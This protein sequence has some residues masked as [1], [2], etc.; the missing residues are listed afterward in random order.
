MNQVQFIRRV[1]KPTVFVLSLL[2]FA[3]LVRAAFSGGL[4]ANPIEEITHTTGT[5]ALTYLMLTLTI[6]PARRLLNLNGLIHLRRMVGLFAFFY[7]SLHFLTYF[8]LD[9]YFDFEAIIEDIAKRPYITIGFVAFSLLVPLAVTSTN[10]MI[11]RLGGK[12]WRRLHRLV[13]V[14]AAGGVLHYLWQVKVEERGPLIYGAI[15]VSLLG[16][17]LYDRRV[18]RPKTQHP[19][20]SEMPIHES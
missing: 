1:I 17:R 18:T 8:T 16:W 19:T 10:R 13:Y 14:A 6:S 9:Q 3:W 15:L 5:W 2:P 11:K 4:G 20:S 12:R 7:A